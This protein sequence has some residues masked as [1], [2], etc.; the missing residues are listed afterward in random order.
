MTSGPDLAAA[1]R[2]WATDVGD[3]SARR[4]RATGIDG[5]T[6]LGR[7]RRAGS[8]TV[9]MLREEGV[10]TTWAIIVHRVRTLLHEARS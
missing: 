10:A 2:E 4:D 9:A 1:V 5:R 8:R 3:R 6:R 7:V